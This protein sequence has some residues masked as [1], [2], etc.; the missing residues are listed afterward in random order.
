[1]T[2]LL[3]AALIEAKRRQQSH[4]MA[5]LMPKGMARSATEKMGF[6][7]VCDMPFHIYGATEPLA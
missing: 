4:S 1:M 7:D 6:E 2:S 5:I 3:Q